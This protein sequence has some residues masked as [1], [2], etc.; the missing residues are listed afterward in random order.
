M[1]AVEFMDS[2]WSTVRQ[3]AAK[4][5]YNMVKDARPPEIEKKSGR[6]LEEK[7]NLTEGKRKRKI[8]IRF[9]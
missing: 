9:K 1:Q 6:Q 3:I 7:N 5:I 4:T 8:R 2:N